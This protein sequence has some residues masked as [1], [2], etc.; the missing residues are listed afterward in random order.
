MK[1]KDT[2][3]QNSLRFYVVKI[4]YYFISL[5]EWYLLF[6]SPLKD[7]ATVGSPVL[8]WEVVLGVLF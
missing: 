5:S 2:H 4:C 8:E 6:C 1:K 3:A 7:G